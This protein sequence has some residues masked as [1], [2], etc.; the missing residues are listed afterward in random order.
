MYFDLVA[1]R[2]GRR[3]VEIIN[4]CEKTRHGIRNEWQPINEVHLES[5]D[6]GDMFLNCS[7]FLNVN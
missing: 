2:S 4:E 6:K 3:I 7:Q 1:L 5:T